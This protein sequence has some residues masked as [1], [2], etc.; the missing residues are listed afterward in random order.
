MTDQARPGA[1]WTK[2]IV[3]P[4]RRI[5]GFWHI[6]AVGDWSRIAA[7][8]YAR[9]K[10]SGL[11][12]ASHK[13]VVGFIGGRGREDE[14]TIPLREDAKFDLFTTA[15]VRDYEF[16][17]LARVWR[18]AQEA[19]QPIFCFYMHTKGA[20]LV[21]TPHQRAA[22]AWRRYMEHFVVENWQDCAAALNTYE[23]CGVELQCEESHYSGNFWWATSEYL[24][25]LPDAEQYWRQHKD[26]RLAAEFYLCLARPKACCFNDCTENLYDYEIKPEDYRR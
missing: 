21:A 13:I 17:T 10:E 22:D 16:P 4:S 3:R 18:A 15:D 7:E 25:R 8:Q 12:D 5:V 19:P 1:T 14:L 23:T 26:D 2:P 11:Y 9:L 24:R 20:S 6:G